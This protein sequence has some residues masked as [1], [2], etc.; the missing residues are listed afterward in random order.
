VALHWCDIQGPRRIEG[1]VARMNNSSSTQDETAHQRKTTLR[2]FRF[3]EE[4]AHALE[5]E[6]QEQGMTLNALVSLILTKHVEWDG[7]AGKFGYIPVYKPVLA[8]L[9]QASDEESLVRMGRTILA[10]MWKEM[11][12]FWYHDTS[13][14]KILDLLSMRSRHLPYVQTEVM[15]EGRRCTIVTHHDLGPN[16]SIVLQGAFDELVRKSFHAQPT[17]SVG[18]T[19]VTVDFPLP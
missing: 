12:S 9:L 5:A 19:V 16:W 8:S 11:A 14:E 3:T 10:P 2:T 1:Q 17:I 15:K 7:K 13:E 6:A 18:E 4:L